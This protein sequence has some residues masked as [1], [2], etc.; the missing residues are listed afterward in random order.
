M[1]ACASKR[2]QS[3]LEAG[4][5]GQLWYISQLTRAVPSLHSLPTVYQRHAADATR[6]MNSAARLYLIGFK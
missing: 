3:A 4:Q 6:G 5:V 2:D 1:Y